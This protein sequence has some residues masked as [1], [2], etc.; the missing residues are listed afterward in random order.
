[1]L[2]QLRNLMV[3][4]LS[5]RDTAWLLSASRTL[6]SLCE[7]V[8]GIRLKTAL[9]ETAMSQMKSKLE[10]R[11]KCRQSKEW[12]KADGIRKEIESAGF[13]IEDTPQGSLIKSR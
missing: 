3:E 9:T 8:L 6:Q 13:A 4:K 12:A 7:D 2:F 1:M 5:L 10:D 11:A